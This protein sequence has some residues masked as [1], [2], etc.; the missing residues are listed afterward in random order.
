MIVC[1]SAF[2][3]YAAL[4]PQTTDANIQKKPH[5]QSFNPNKNHPNKNYLLR[6]Y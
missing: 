3:S 6:I 2:Q 4:F 1:T 5:I